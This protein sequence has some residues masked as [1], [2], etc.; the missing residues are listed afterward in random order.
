MEK[1]RLDN[2]KIMWMI[3]ALAW[4][5]MVEQALQTVVQYADAAMVGSIGPHASAAVGLTTT[6]TWLTNA[7]LF[8][9]GIGVLACISRAMGAGDKSYARTAAVQA[10]YIAAALGILESILMVGISPFLPVWLGADVEIRQEATVYFAITCMPML[11]RAANVIFGSVLRATRDMKTPMVVNLVVNVLNVILNF[12]LIYGSRNIAVGGITIPLWGAGLGVAGAAIATALSQTLGG[13]LMFRAIRK[14]KLLDMK[15]ARYKLDRIVMEQCVR[16]GFPVALERIFTSLGQVV[17]TGLVTQLG[18][19]SLAAHSIALTAEQAFY[20]PGFG[21]QAAASTLAGNAVG[22]KNEEK[23]DR[24][25][26]II[27]WMAVGVM[28]VTG[29]LLFI[30][31]EPMMSLFTRDAAVIAEGTQALRIVALSEP[32]FAAVIILKGILNGAGDTK[33]PF[34]ISISTMW[35]VR[36]LFTFISVTMM[37]LGLNAVW[38]C[39]V[40]DN[41]SQF[42]LLAIKFVKGDWK[43]RVGFS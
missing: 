18:T 32:M 34:L 21:M 24:I 2:R 41:V 22:E 31:P 35:G 42:V 38:I 7:P 15:S 20:I 11:F 33:T 14:N 6:M 9:M 25:S 1:E 27:T 8:A 5:T 29:A 43:K 39:M 12:L 4:P 30:F 17:F 3:C 23:L 26:K 37:G 16:I 10:V 36:I 28:T 19:I 40:A 13:I